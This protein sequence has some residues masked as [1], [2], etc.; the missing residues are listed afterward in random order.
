MKMTKKSILKRFISAG[1]TMVISAGVFATPAYAANE[2]INEPY[3]YPVVPGTEEWAELMSFPEKIE[4]CKIPEGKAEAMSTE[5][6]IETILN[7]PIWTIYF[8]Y[9]MESVY[10]IYSEDIIVALQELEQREDADELLLA[11]YQADQVAPMSLNNATDENGSKSEFLEILLAQPVFYDDLNEV[12]LEAL[13]E[14]AAKKA[15]IRQTNKKA[16]VNESPFYSVL[17]TQ[18]NNLVTTRANTSYV[19]TPNLT[20]VSVEVRT[21]N[22]IPDDVKTFESYFEGLFPNCRKISGASSIYNCHSYAWHLSAWNNPYWMPDPRD[23]WGDGSYVKYNPGSYFQASTRAVFKIGSTNN[24]D[25]WH[26]VLIR[27]AYT[28]TT[29]YVVAESKWGPYGLYEHYLLDNPWA[30]NSSWV[31]HGSQYNIT[32]YKRA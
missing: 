9:D 28:G 29:K 1:I 5:A 18:K 25:N 11:R 15:E 21:Y 7:H 17:E 23:Y 6:L 2:L 32:Y 4:I 24:A 10:D 8:V 22:D 26:S 12:E 14:E 31:T 16:Y 20:K 30:V 13:D 3:E 19:Y 27:K